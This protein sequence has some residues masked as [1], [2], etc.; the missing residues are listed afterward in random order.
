MSS[1]ITILHI[2]DLHYFQPS[3]L[4]SEFSIQRCWGTLNYQ[5]KTKVQEHEQIQERLLAT[6][7]QESWD[8]LFLTGDI[9]IT[10]TAQELLWAKHKLHSLFQQG[11]VYLLPGN[12]DRY[13]PKAEQQDEFGKCYSALLPYDWKVFRQ[14]KFFIQELSEDI[15][16]LGLDTVVPRPLYSSRG[17]ISTA[18]LECCSLALQQY[19]KKY[20]YKIAMGHYPFWT[21]PSYKDPYC[22]RCL[23]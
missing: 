7:S 19:K 22:F 12:H 21:P 13:L 17:T 14:Q 9:T 11:R 8:V 2:S 10:G 15:L 4:F 20:R 6:I 3:S 5:R 23:I 16:L 18:V 1:T